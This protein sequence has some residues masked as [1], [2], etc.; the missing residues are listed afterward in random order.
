MHSQENVLVS[1]SFFCIWLVC[2]ITFIAGADPDD[3]MGMVK[4][5][6]NY[7]PKVCGDAGVCKRRRISPSARVVPI[8]MGIRL[9]GELEAPVL[10]N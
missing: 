9:F 6:K 5:S 4:G 1:A 7:E 10:F 3:T 2:T 8:R